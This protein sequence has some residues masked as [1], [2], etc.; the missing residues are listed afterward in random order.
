MAGDPSGPAKAPPMRNRAL[1][2]A[3]R[4]FVLEAAALLV[5]T[6]EAGE[7]IAF[8]LDEQSGGGGTLYRYRPLTDDFIAARWGQIRALPGFEAAAK[9]LGTGAR[10]YLRR[11]GEPGADAEPALRA[12]L[13]RLYEDSTSFAFP[14]ERFER[15]YAGVE[16]AL[17]AG[18]VRTTLAAPVL[19]LSLEGA[20]LEL[21]EDLAL[22]DAALLARAPSPSW[23]EGDEESEGA[24]TAYL[25]LERDIGSDAPLPLGEARVRFGAALAALRLLEPSGVVLAPHGFARAG[26]GGWQAFRLEGSGCPHGCELTVDSDDGPRLCRLVQALEERRRPSPLGWALDRYGMG[27]ARPSE[28]EALS[29]HLLA[30]RALLGGGSAAEPATVALRLAALRTEEADRRA[31]QRRVEAAFALE[32]FVIEGGVG[33]ARGERYAETVGRHGPGPLVRE[34]EEHLCGLLADALFGE[35]DEDLAG[36]ADERLLRGSDPVEIRAGRLAGRARDEEE[37][38]EDEPSEA[39]SHRGFEEGGEG[40]ER[41]HAPAASPLAAFPGRLAPAHGRREAARS[42]EAPTSSLAAPRGVDAAPDE[43]APLTLAPDL[44]EDPAGYSAPV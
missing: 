9:A 11:R 2:D 35:L 5:R 30:L 29:D 44:D 18:T 34:L 28:A 41:P 25:V 33:A 22:A 27:L 7:E 24:P 10:A 23:L 3:L 37:R 4:D 43:R 31:V 1:H 8:S 21:G 39:A 17:Y 42:R 26:E 13:E 16:R 6:T 14:E 20:R 19:G 40:D 12:L 32:P 15:V 38:E 36:A